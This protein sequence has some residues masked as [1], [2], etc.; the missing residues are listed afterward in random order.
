MRGA[1]IIGT[2]CSSVIVLPCGKIKFKKV[3]LISSL[4]IDLAHFNSISV[5]SITGLLRNPFVYK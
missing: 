5:K 1:A 3:P 2:A 4:S